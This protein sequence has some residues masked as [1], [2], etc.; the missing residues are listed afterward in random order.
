[1]SQEF[2]RHVLAFLLPGR[3]LAL[4]GLCLRAAYDSSIWLILLLCQLHQESQEGPPLPQARPA[5][6]ALQCWCG[7]DGHLHHTRLHAGE[8]EGRRQF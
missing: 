7:Q 5:A 3:C 1:M 2:Q 8:D 4:A 6:G